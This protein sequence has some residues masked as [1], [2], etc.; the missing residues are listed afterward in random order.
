MKAGTY[1]YTAYDYANTVFG[2]SP[3]HNISDSICAKGQMHVSQVQRKQLTKI[4]RRV[5]EVDGIIQADAG[6]QTGTFTSQQ[7]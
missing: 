3:N 4:I 1:S 6:G 5:G 2:E 7:T